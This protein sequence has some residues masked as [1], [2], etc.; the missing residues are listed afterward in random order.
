MQIDQLLTLVKS[1]KERKFEGQHLEIKAAAVDCPSKLYDTLSSFSNQE[2]GGVILFGVDES[3]RFSVCGVYDVQDLQKK[4]T[5][6]C[7][8]MEPPVRAVFTSAEID[9]KQVVAAEVPSVAVELRPVYYRGRGMN[10][11]SYVRV[12]DADEPMTDREVYAYEAFRKHAHDD[13]R[14]IDDPRDDVSTVDSSKLEEFVRIVK[15]S[16]PNL[17]DNMTDA[18]ILSLQGVRIGE[19]M[20]LAGELAFSRYPQAAFPQYCV[21]AVRVAGTE[22]G[23]LGPEGERFVDSARITGPVADMVKG[24]VDFVA[25]NSRSSVTITDD[26]DRKDKL[27]YPLKAIREAVLNALVHRDYSIHAQGIPVRVEMYQ[28]RIEIINE[29]GLFGHMTVGRLGKERGDPR[30]E[31]L[32]AILDTMDVTENRYSGIP[33][34]LRECARHGLPPPEF[35]SRRGEFRVVIRNSAQTDEVRFDPSDPKASLVRFC[36]ERRSR[37]DLL[38]FTGLTNSYLMS[39][40]VYPLV[41]AHRLYLSI[42]TKPKSENQQFSSIPL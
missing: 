37:G 32:V 8:E 22:M 3:N 25:R 5:G 40:Y 18:Q 17:R 6:Q 14:L 23:E 20:T 15:A 41:K 9:G 2:E 28:D 7:Q 30:N 24:A 21:T 13:L 12:G 35:V 10:G 36:R 42:P 1:V 31:T 38:R 34:I 26:G 39:K 4:V 16:S 29:G 19:K 27:E 11:G 33:T